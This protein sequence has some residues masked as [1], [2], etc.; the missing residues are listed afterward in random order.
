[1][2]FGHKKLETLHCHMLKT[3][4]QAGLES[5]P[6]HDRQTDRIMTVSMCLALCAIARKNHAWKKT[7]K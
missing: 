5:V 2:K 1:M 4:S 7:A 6:G 3:W